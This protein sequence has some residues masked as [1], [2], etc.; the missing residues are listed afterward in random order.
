MNVMRKLKIMRGLAVPGLASMLLVSSLAGYTQQG[1]LVNTSRSGY[2][3][4]TGTGMSDVQWTTGFWAD[5]FAVC[6][7]AMVPHLWDT[8]NDPVKCHSFKNFEIAAG[9]DTGKFK[10]PS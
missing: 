4:L 1:S 7:D 10:G 8:Y 2:A 3:R 9:L 5:R 6:R